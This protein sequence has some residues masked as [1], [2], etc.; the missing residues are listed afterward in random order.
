MSKCGI[1]DTF[2]LN[3]LKPFF[4]VQCCIRTIPEYDALTNCLNY[5]STLIVLSIIVCS[6]VV[7][8]PPGLLDV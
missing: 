4:F 5:L 1:C 8:L 3:L 7:R 6:E 2:A